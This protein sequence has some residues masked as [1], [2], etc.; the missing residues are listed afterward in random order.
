MKLLEALFCDDVRFEV[1]NKLSLMGLYSDR[2]VFRTAPEKEL[3]W[4]LPIRLAT[5]LRFRLDP[6]DDR[7]DSFDFE[8]FMNEKSIVKLAGQMRSDSAQTYMNLT[9][10]VEGIPLELG[11]LGF[12]IT[13][14]KGDKVIFSEEQKHAL[15]VLKE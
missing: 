4:P 9:V 5:L 1:N 14:K 2:I 6:K 10:N 3:K 8:Y 12:S 13:L 15:K 7:P 11:A